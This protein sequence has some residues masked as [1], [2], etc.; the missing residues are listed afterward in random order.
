MLLKKVE[1][2]TGHRE[3]QCR[4]TEEDQNDVQDEP[5][6]AN[7]R[8]RPRTHRISKGGDQ[9]HHE[10]QGKDE[11]TEAF[12]LIAPMDKEVCNRYQ[13]RAHR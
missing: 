4:E 2:G 12:Q 3:Q 10:N 8:A 7:D 11:H 6:I 1:Q 9:R 5:R 13:K